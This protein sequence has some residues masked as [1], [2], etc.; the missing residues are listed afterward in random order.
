MKRILGIG[1]AL[2]D[3]LARIDN[4]K[5]LNELSLPKG[6]MQLIDETRFREFGRV[7]ESMDT[8]RA[9]GG[10]AANTILAIARL[11]G[12]SGFIGKI[13][14][15][16]TGRFF[17]DHF[18][19]SGVEVCLKRSAQAS[20]VASTFISPDGE[21]TF[22]TYLGAAADL[23]ANDLDASIFQGYDYFYVEG[24][25]VQNHA[26]IDRAIGLAHEAGLQ[27]CL[28]MASYN[29]VEEDYD[30]FVHLVDRADIVFANADEARVFTGKGPHEAADELVR[31][32]RIA[33][34]KN[35]KKGAVIRGDGQAFDVPALDVPHVVDTT[36][37]GD[38]FAAGF[39]YGLS[40][41]AP[42]PGC[43]ELGSLLAGQVI[44]VAGTRLPETVWDEV[45]A[46]PLLSDSDKV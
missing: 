45:L 30:F 3:V 20:G 42:L 10:S 16:E 27:V 44:Q 15:D 22:G 38:F 2:V 37:A 34:V 18:R 12:Q 6:S 31:T 7:M 26:L 13:G 33:V 46:S 24:Y 29:I 28:D 19:K 43:A 1:N 4:D 32:C 35:G 41:G 36:A 23:T 5:I 14:D 11:G 21:R 9:T 25:L 39:L 17:A 8:E 40:D